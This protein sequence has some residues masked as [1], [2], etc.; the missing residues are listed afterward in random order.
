M[1]VEGV[2]I[3]GGFPEASFVKILVGPERLVCHF[4]LAEYGVL[5]G[6]E[7]TDRN[8]RAGMK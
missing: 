5:R 6:Q 3:K 8:E 7:R 4:Q 2:E 1:I